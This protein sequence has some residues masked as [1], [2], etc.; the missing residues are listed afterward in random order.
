M[1]DR[2]PIQIYENLMQKIGG[3]VEE[4]EKELAQLKKAE[5]Q[6]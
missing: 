3:L 5:Q 2:S 6:E 4:A 1:K